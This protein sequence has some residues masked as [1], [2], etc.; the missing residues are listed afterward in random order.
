MSG[1]KTEDAFAGI[2]RQPPVI[3]EEPIVPDRAPEPAKL[4]EASPAGSGPE[5]EKVR[6]TGAG[7][8]IAAQLRFAA[9]PPA[10]GRRFEAGAGRIM[11]EG[12]DV[13]A[14]PRSASSPGPQPVV[15][16]E[17]PHMGS[18]VRKVAGVRYTAAPP[19][20]T[21]P[22]SDVPVPGAAT[23]TVSGVDIVAIPPRR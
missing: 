19:N 16:A 17:F 13:T 23:R 22:A 10:S 6:G 4:P 21:Q 1:V 18:G 5:K 12:I 9:V 14:V 15:G 8:R 2:L 3:Y 20:G 7:M 11:V